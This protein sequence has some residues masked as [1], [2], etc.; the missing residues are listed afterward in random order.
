MNLVDLVIVCIVNAFVR[1]FVCYLFVVHHCFSYGITSL[2]YANNEYNLM[3]CHFCIGIRFSICL[4]VFVCKY[5]CFLRTLI[6]CKCLKIRENNPR[7][8]YSS[9]GINLNIEL[10]AFANE[11]STKIVP[12]ERSMRLSRDVVHLCSKECRLN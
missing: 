3:M 8:W 10:F 1:Y 7:T 2:P 9:T 11:K 6:C 4:N 5:N 12:I